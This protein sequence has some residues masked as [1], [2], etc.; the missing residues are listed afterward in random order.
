[1][2]DEYINPF[3]ASVRNTFQTMLS[4]EAQRGTPYLRTAAESDFCVSG[5]IGLSGNAVGTIVLNMSQEVA[6]GI[7][8]ALLMDRF[9]ELTADVIDAVGELTNVIAGAAKSKLEEFHLGVSLPNVVTGS[10]P[11]DPLP[12]R[13]DTHLRALH[14]DLGPAGPRS[15]PHARA[16]SGGRVAALANDITMLGSSPLRSRLDDGPVLDRMVEAEAHTIHLQGTI[17][18]TLRI[19]ALLSVFFLFGS[20]GMAAE[21]KYPHAEMLIEPSTLSKAE[22]AKQFIILD[23]REQKLYDEGHVPGAVW[24]DAAAWAKAFKDGKD[25]EG[26]SARIGK[27]GINADSKVVVYDDHSFNEAARI[28]WILRYWGVEDVRLLNGN[29][30]TWKKAG[31]PSRPASR[32][33]RRPS[34]SRPSRGPSGWRPRDWSWP[35]SKTAACKSWMPAPRA[36]SVAPTNSRTSVPGQSPGPSTWNGST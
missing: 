32:N 24:V 2:R 21:T 30:T 19:V 26:W 4:S 34:N 33:R 17:K 35:R 16:A 11:H 8:S 3:I 7:A 13:R 27:L 6:L 36:N 15:R 1:M 9:T 22:I 28:W 25:A 29:W 5:V 10:A 18:M 23:A 12:Q 14:N 20:R 31:L